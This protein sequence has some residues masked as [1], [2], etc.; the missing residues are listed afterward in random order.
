MKEI[1]LTPKWAGIMRIL[2]EVHAHGDTE[3]GRHSAAEE[4]MRL[5]KHM[6]YI[7]ENALLFAAAP[8]L[9]A[10]LSELMECYE[11]NSGMSL[12]PDTYKTREKCFK[13]LEKARGE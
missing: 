4:I 9:L 7:N 6:D 5:A 10:A 2:L 1:D 3:E 8:D 11:L 13:A 12:E